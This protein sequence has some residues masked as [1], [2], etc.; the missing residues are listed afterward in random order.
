VKALRSS[1]TSGRSYSTTRCKI[2][3]KPIFLYQPRCICHHFNPLNTDLNRICH[4]LALLGAQHI[5]HVSGLRVN[6]LTKC[7]LEVINVRER[8]ELENFAPC[9]NL[10][11][12]VFWV[13]TQPLVAISYRRFGT[14]YRS[15]RQG[16]RMKKKRNK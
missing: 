9:I 10:R 12:A 6:T 13:I 15:H 14:T 8:K 3:K 5:F 16:S 11:N 7:T 4:L 1:E 2:K